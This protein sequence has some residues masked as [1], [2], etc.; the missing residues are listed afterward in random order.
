[1][2]PID[3]DE[4]IFRVHTKVLKLERE[5]EIL[6]D[7]TH[8]Q[9]EDTVVNSDYF[10]PKYELKEKYPDDN[11]I[12]KSW[13]PRFQCNDFWYNKQ[14]GI[15]EVNRNRMLISIDLSWTGFDCTNDF[16]RIIVDDIPREYKTS[17]NLKNTFK[18]KVFEHRGLGSKELK[19]YPRIDNSTI[20]SLVGICVAGEDTNTIV[21]GDMESEGYIKAECRWEIKQ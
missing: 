4:K 17:F 16:L 10:Y 5:I 21:T 19:F 9:N 18:F 2:E 15:Y 3:L 8:A 13:S 12:A 11:Y 7:K 1:M 6:K 14:I 20:P